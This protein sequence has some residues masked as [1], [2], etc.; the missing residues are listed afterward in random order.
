MRRGFKHI[1]IYTYIYTYIYI[2][3]YR[4]GSLGLRFKPRS[5]DTHTHSRQARLQE[6]YPVSVLVF[7]ESRLARKGPCALGAEPRGRASPCHVGGHG[8]HAQPT[9]LGALA[10]DP[11]M[12]NSTLT[13]MVSWAIRRGQSH[14]IPNSGLLGLASLH[15]VWKEPP[16]VPLASGSVAGTAIV[17]GFANQTT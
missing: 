7:S 13:E 5:L 6:E 2:Y 16:S 14:T 9:C 10:L 12:P 17:S 15:Q 8:D 3:K 11:E 1:Y 4:R